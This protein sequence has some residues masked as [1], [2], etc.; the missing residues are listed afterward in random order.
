M[1]HASCVSGWL[2]LGSSFD[3]N[4]H[5]KI[6]AWVCFHA[7]CDFVRLCSNMCHVPARLTDRIGSD[8]IVDGNGSVNGDG[9]GNGNGNK[10]R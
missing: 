4:V 1:S 2:A 9:S 7:S 5:S 10:L 8:G 3:L 6:V